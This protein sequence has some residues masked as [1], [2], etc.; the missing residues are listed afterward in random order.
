MWEPNS[1]GLGRPWLLGH[2]HTAADVFEV[3]T[4]HTAHD[5]PSTQSPGQGPQALGLQSKSCFGPKTLQLLW[6]NEGSRQCG[7]AV[8]DC[9]LYKGA[10]WLFRWADSDR[11]QPMCQLSYAQLVHLSQ[12]FPSSEFLLKHF[13]IWWILSSRDS[14][15]REDEGLSGTLI[16][17]CCDLHWAGGGFKTHLYI[18]WGQFSLPAALFSRREAF[19]RAKKKELISRLRL[20]SSH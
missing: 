18:G 12:I 20:M 14:Q 1:R 13:F 6:R 8:L 11:T 19:W 4:P 3:S 5:N 15:L 2:P 16:Y 17:H 9:G 10:E 7:L